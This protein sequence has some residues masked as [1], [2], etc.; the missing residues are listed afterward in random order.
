[1][2]VFEQRA[3][4]W[5]LDGVLV[6]SGPIHFLSWK[7]IL[8][9]YGRELTPETFA[10]AFGMTTADTILAL[11]G[12]DAPVETIAARKEALFRTLLSGQT[13]ALPGAV[14]WL[15]RLRQLGVK[16]ALASSAPPENIT[17]QLG[18][19]DGQQYF[20][21]IVSGQGQPGK[22]D[23]YV[24]IEAA[25]RLGVTAQHCVVIEDSIAGVQA[26]Q[27]AGMHCIAVTNTFRADDLTKAGAKRIVSSLDELT[28]ADFL[29]AVRA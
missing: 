2:Q 12:P 6:D 18:A 7:Q 20:D 16:Q 28:E 8:A 10:P 19:L 17:A 26:A 9:E 27:R 1:M 29:G 15:A 11:L 13:V 22:P 21:T 23:P 4:L 14:R 3:V 5:D 24:F 25:R